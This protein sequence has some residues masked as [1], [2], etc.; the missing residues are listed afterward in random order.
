M[1]QSVVP[2]LSEIQRGPARKS[3]SFNHQRRSFFSPQDHC[4]AILDYLCSK[5][6]LRLESIDF[7]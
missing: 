6:P 3:G 5:Q 2:T 7:K 4:T 1:N